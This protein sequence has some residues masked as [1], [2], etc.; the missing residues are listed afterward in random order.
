MTNEL[1]L[2]LNY[3]VIAG[4]AQ[5]VVSAFFYFV[6]INPMGP[7][8]W[9]SIFIPITLCYLGVKNYRDE[10][11]KGEITYG[12]AFR[13]SVSLGFFYASFSAILIYFFGLTIATDL[14]EIQ[15]QEALKGFE[16]LRQ[17][18]NDETLFDKVIEELNKMNIAR[19]AW[20]DFQNKWLGMVITGLVVAGI[21]KK[22]KP[23]FDNYPTNE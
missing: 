3:S 13:V 9:I 10:I 4:L 22:E 11:L 16:I 21:L 1:K 23:L 7:I 19:L 2:I 15:K 6:G 17:Y 14:I 5:F 20:G 12:K 18:S 8:S